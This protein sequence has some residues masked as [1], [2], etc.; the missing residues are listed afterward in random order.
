M[1]DRPIS[2]LG[3]APVFAVDNCSETLDYYGEKLGFKVSATRGDPPHYGVVK[4]DNVEIHFSERE[5]TSEKLQPGNAYVT[6]TDVDAIY[7]EYCSKGLSIFS[8]PEDK[9]HG[10]REFEIADCNGHFLT[11]GQPVK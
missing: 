1:A 7:D 11:F 9:D 4:R 3:C 10:M 5:D 8:P 2:M 6:A